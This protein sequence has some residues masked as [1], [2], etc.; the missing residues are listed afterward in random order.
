MMS[1]KNWFLIMLGVL[2]VSLSVYA[3]TTRDDS[4]EVRTSDYYESAART[5]GKNGDY[6][7][8]KRQVD[9][10]LR[11][12]PE[13]TGLNELAGSYYLHAKD[14]DR[15]RFYLVKSVQSNNENVRSKQMLVDVEEA[16]HNYSSAICYVNE[17]LEV[18]P[19]WRGLWRRK[20]ALYRKQGN[21]VMADHLLR[22]ICQIYPNDSTLRRELV[23]RMDEEYRND[24]RA[25]NSKAAIDKLEQ[26]VDHSP[27]NEQY[28]L[29]LANLYLQQGNTEDAIRVAGQGASRLPGSMA[30]IRK[31]A[32][33]LAEESRY[34]EALAFLT[35]RM[36]YSR[37]GNLRT[38][39]SDL[40]EEQA[41]AE[42][43]RDP[44]VL[45]GRVYAT[46]HSRE[47]L[48]YLLNTAFSRGYD[49]DAL[50]YIAEAKKRG[51][52][53]IALTYKEYLVNKRLG[54][55]DRA[56]ALLEKLYAE[57]PSN[58]EFAEEVARTRLQDADRLMITENYAEALPLLDLV[59][60]KAGDD[61]LVRAA[62]SR[63]FTCN[64]RL[65][66]YGQ[67]LTCLEQIH[68]RYPDSDDYV[69]RKAA[70]LKAQ[71]HPATALAFLAETLS[72][73]SMDSTIRG[74]WVNSY[75][76]IAL[77]YIKGLLEGGDAVKALDQS[78]RLLAVYPSSA[79]GLRY[80]ITASDL[81][82]NK[83]DY[84]RYTLVAQSYYPS[85]AV[86]LVKRS[87]VLSRNAQY[88][89]ALDML[90]P[91]LDSLP[92][93]KMLVGAFSENSEQRALQL[94]HARRAATAMAVLDTAL[95][96]DGANRSL[97]YTKGLAFEALHRYD[98]AYVYQRA[99]QPAAIEVA[100][101]KRHLEMLQA[102]GDRNT[103]GFEYLQ[104]RYAEADILT[105][106]ATLSYER[107]GDRNT[108]T[109]R[110]NYA[111]R[112]GGDNVPEMYQTPGGVGVQMQAEWT[113]KFS[114]RWAGTFSAAWAN[115]YFPQV[116]LSAGATR[117]LRNDWTLDGIVAFRRIDAYDKVFAWHP[118]ESAPAGQPDG[119]W[120]L[121]GWKRSHLNLL[122]AG[123][124]ASKELGQFALDG[125]ADAFLI[126]SSFYVNLR[127]RAK[128]YP[129]DDRR[130]SIM[131]M[132][133]AG[134]AP[135]VTMIDNAQ[136]GAFDKLNTMVGLGGAYALTRHVTLGLIGTWHTFYNPSV[137]RQ[138]TPAGFTDATTFNY[139]NL[140]NVYG[141]VFI[142]F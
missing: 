42:S 109:G 64:Y 7:G 49:E 26:L 19:Y 122:T 95:T 106:V 103:V 65:G 40:E 6:A 66:R 115:R 13:A 75:E 119:A 81:L 36:R 53:T 86:F 8:M 70:V 80:A 117:Y 138:G 134:T 55:Q 92:A 31:K 4:K 56:R 93:N 1:K 22:R 135:E 44:Y 34:P 33:I 12:Y 62:Y 18:N 57:Q 5:C 25:G 87:V 67:A 82:H 130:T 116:A 84:D 139:R 51:G 72:K 52:N 2:F 71:G 41:R 121:T 101:F 131:A 124:G 63:R 54:N 123:V 21:E 35:E 78:K 61:E 76:E 94:I 74:V 58:E 10:G 89:A 16:T 29:D 85:D 59:V 110:I 114:E 69:T 136:P 108:V 107:R 132:C 24:R 137:A 43:R 99:Y 100:D 46:R 11:H 126:S 77:P 112:D 30:L 32:G 104:G 68:A 83:G 111:G 97:L 60:A 142:N 96:F 37:N 45:Y 48:D 14:Y 9:E 118:A 141:Q 105:S 88:A 20:I 38:L 79:D 125:H 127:A 129:F 128:Y 39:Y 15:A 3:V 91:A 23:A 98:S 102:S 17:L 113:H 133:S 90:R 27:T 73:T 120:V 47:A 50:H 28:Y 140:Y